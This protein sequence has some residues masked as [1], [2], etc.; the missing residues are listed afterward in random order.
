MDTNRSLIKNLAR[1]MGAAI[2][3]CGLL[4]IVSWQ[5]HWQ[6]IVQMLPG[7]APMQFNT[8]LCFIIS[9]FALFLLTT[10]RAKI[11]PYLGGLLTAFTTLTLLE[12][13]V[14]SQLGLDVLFFKPYFEAATAYPG[15]MSPLAA[16]C[17]ILIGI[18]LLLA[19]PNRGRP[20]R[21]AIAGL[22][23][24]VVVVIASAALIGF[25]FGIESAYGW[26]ADSSMAVNTAALFLVLGIGLLMSTMQTAR[27]QAYN[28][29]HWLPTTASVTLMV[30][31]AFV[32]AGD[33]KGLNAATFWRKHTIETILAA[34]SFEND[35][36]DLQRGMR[37]YVTTGDTNGLAAFHS[38]AVVERQRLDELT[39][40]TRDDAVQQQQLKSLADAMEALFSYDGRLI[41]IYN[42]QGAMAIFKIDA[43]GQG[44]AVFGQAHDLLKEF[45]QT[46]QKLLSLRDVS[47]EAGYRN[48]EHLLVVS[49]ALAA[50]LL[51]TANFMASR[52]LARRRLAEARL[53]ARAHALRRSNAEL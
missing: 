25:I 21:L 1:G 31:V 2:V 45:S 7:T 23:M 36:I 16:V 37:G 30:M 44:R 11:A 19:N 22:L 27:E 17:F 47:E 24:C 5:E 32:A 41:E 4:V 9:G 49:C 48:T 3:F 28:F 10:S 39:Q 14:G 46:E 43:T 42:Q 38:T 33:V 52:E 15:R 12:Y 13:I 35:L 8:A 18:A 34:Q 53:E 29:F 26:G 40:L 6:R 20:R 50:L 51:F